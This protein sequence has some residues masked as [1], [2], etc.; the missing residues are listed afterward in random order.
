MNIG[1]MKE[2]FKIAHTAKR[3]VK[4]VGLHGIGKSQIVSQFGKDNGYHVEILQLPLMD[5]GDLMGI[6]VTEMVDGET[7]LLGQSQFGSKESIQQLL[8][9]FQLF[10]S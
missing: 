1:K 7:I 8:K 3:S 4:M 5:E 6:P 9:V 2:V 10:C